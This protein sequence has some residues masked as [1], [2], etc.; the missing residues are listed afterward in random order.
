MVSSH[1]ISH[2]PQQKQNKKTFWL[3]LLTF[4]GTFLAWGC[5]HE[6]SGVIFYAHVCIWSH[7]H[8]SMSVT[9]TKNPTNILC[10]MS[11]SFTANP[12]QCLMSNVKCP[13]STSL[14]RTP[15]N[16]QCLMSNVLCPISYVQCLHLLLRTPTSK[17]Q[18]EMALEMNAMAIWTEMESRMI[19]MS[20]PSMA[21]SGRQGVVGKHT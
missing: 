3:D 9:V 8:R 16:V 15:T 17:I 18:T 12:D 6:V 11:K 1:F 20:V 7:I 5:V 10:P 21:W 13:M 2:S 14:L 19:S 4:V